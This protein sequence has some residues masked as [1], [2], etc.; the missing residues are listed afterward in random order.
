MNINELKQA[1]ERNRSFQ[2]WEKDIGLSFEDFSILNL[3]GD[4]YQIIKEGKKDIGHYSI[5][6]KNGVL[7]SFYFDFDN[8][9]VRQHNLKRIG[10]L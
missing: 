1:L 6:L 2:G 10:Y 9:T 7:E 8:E 5:N 3:V 4:K